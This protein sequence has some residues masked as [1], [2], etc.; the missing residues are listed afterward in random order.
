[1]SRTVATIGAAWPAVAQ[2]AEDSERG[3]QTTVAPDE[4]RKNGMRP[5][6]RLVW[7]LPLRLTHWALVVSVAG[8][9]ATHYAGAEWFAW[10][11]RLGYVTLVLVLFRLVWGFVGTR[12]ARFAGFLRGPAVVLAY[13]RGGGRDP[14]PGHNPLGAWSVVAMLAVLLVQAGTGLAAN[15][16][17]ANAGPFY[18][19]TTQDLSNRITSVHEFNSNLV[20]G[21]V[22]LHLVA[23]AWYSRARRLPLVRA[24]VSGRKDAALVA[25]RDAI[26]SSRTGLAIVIAALIAGALAIA[27]RLAPEG[28]IALF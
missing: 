2:A 28:M 5:T 7:D 24:M 17:I 19:W 15:D 25:A 20:L 27:V 21:L 12:H 8:A 14:T 6:T 26:D 22:A 13:V 18:G 3:M 4:G 10:H 23:V 11:R 9:W 1:M 16:E